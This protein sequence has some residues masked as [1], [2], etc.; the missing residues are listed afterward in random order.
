MALLVSDSHA[1]KMVH[2]KTAELLAEVA[3]KVGFLNPTIELWQ[4]K[5]STSH[6]YLLH[7][8]ILILTK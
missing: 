2:I 8:N 1:F 4:K 3:K 7:E 5:Y 6:K